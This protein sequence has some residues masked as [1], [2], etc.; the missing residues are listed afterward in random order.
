[1]PRKGRRKPFDVTPM[2]DVDNS[3]TAR[4]TVCFC[5]LAALCEGF[6]VQAAGVAA[7]GLSHDLHPTS[8]ELGIFFAASGAGLLVGALVGGRIADRVGRKAVLVSSIAMFGFFS[9]L[10][11]VAWDMQSLSA[12]RL[13]TGLGLGGAMPNLIALAADA[14]RAQS[15]NASIAITYI[16]MPLGAVIASMI[17]LLVPLEAWRLVFRVGGIAP[18][19]MVPL[20]IAFMPVSRAAPA[21]HASAAIRATGI[22]SELFGQGRWPTTVLLWVAFFLIVLTLHLML[23]WLPL[24]LLGRGLIK[25]QAAFAQVGFNVGGAA[26]ALWMGTLLDSRWQRLSI[27]V[28]VV[29]LPVMLFLIATSPPQAALLLV[30]ASLLGGGILAEQVI[31]Y[32]VASAC[33]PLAAR[34]TGMGA[35]VAAGRLG[36]LVGPLFVAWLI[37]AGRSPAQVLVGV[38]PI[39]IVCGVCVGILGWCIFRPQDALRGEPGPAQSLHS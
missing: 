37:A 30:L 22:L 33:Y 12:A 23:N 8:S 31:V 19:I 2:P 7:A 38:L 29:T 1:M 39:V 28:S 32:A 14:S 16:G 15:R 35:A 9:L 25:T 5:F 18:L 27:A 34:G 24:L 11:S 4:L 17:I 21:A 3:P 13:L 6:D 26:A 10:T 20:M 36:S